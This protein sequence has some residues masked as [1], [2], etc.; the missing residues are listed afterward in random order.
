MIHYNPNDET[1]LGLKFELVYDR[2]LYD[3]P[4]VL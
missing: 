3:H 2:C 4:E 1:Y